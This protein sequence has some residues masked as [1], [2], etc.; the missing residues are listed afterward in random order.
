[1]SEAARPR[2]RAL[3]IGYGNALRSDDGF[4]W[5]VAGRL[6]AD[7]RA[8]GLTV[9]RRHQLTPELAVEISEASLV[10]FVDARR[11]AAGE[12]AVDAVEAG[13]GAEAGPSLSHHVGPASL[14]ALAR[15]LYG[16]APS[17]VAVA[18]G[19]ASDGAGEELSPAVAAVVPEA[20]E[21]ILQLVDRGVAGPT[22]P[23]GAADA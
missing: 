23:V 16:R 19:M 3:V 11:G 14:I 12:L 1:M 18:A 13:P 21:R 15:E 9:L 7:P 8:I 4:G 10:V 20:V 5:H 6:A 22:L 17:A 2:G